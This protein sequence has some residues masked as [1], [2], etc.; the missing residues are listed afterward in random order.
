MP[1]EYQTKSQARSRHDKYAGKIEKD[2]RQVGSPR[3]Q[4]H[5]ESAC[6]N[7]QG[8][9]HAEDDERRL[10]QHPA[11]IAPASTG[12]GN[13]ETHRNIKQKGE[14]VNLEV[15]RSRK[16]RMDGYVGNSQDG[17]KRKRRNSMPA[18]DIKRVQAKDREIAAKTEEEYR[19]R[20]EGIIIDRQPPAQ[21]DNEK[22][23]PHVSY[24]ETKQR[25]EDTHNQE[26][27]NIP[28]RAQQ[29][30]KVAIVVGASVPE[31]PEIVNGTIAGKR[32]AVDLWLETREIGS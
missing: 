21:K 1:V 25:R 11:G 8:I 24:E 27:A 30:D 13:Q 4:H 9:M 19:L 6:D 23:F 22:Q 10:R 20:N 18:K 16:E 3:K 15:G 7:D 2:M 32:L 5:A 26:V 28:Q 12:V 14:P 31:H 29:R 17:E